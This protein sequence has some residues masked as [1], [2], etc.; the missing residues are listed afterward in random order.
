MAISRIETNSI[1][2]SQTLTTPI[3]ATTMG[4]G[5]ATPSGSGSG[6][7]F[8]ATQSAS[9]DATTLDDY[10]EGTFEASF[11]M[12][13]SGSATIS[14]SY[15]TLGYTKIGNT[16]FITGNPRVDSVSSPSGYLNLNGLPFAVA[17]G[18]AGNRVGPVMSYYDTSDATPYIAV[19]CVIVENT[20]N[21]RV[22]TTEV[23]FTVAAG[24]EIL[25]GFCYR[26]T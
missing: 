1:A 2:P 22:L 23:G 24:D 7:T 3:I 10:E 12:S 26:T 25:L 16:V 18:A 11:S 20:T 13:V 14:T 17:N 15:K 4:V 6:I 19:P 5:G 21:V 8:P 9:N